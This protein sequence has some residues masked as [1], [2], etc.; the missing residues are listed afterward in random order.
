[1][2]GD[3]SGSR[4]KIGMTAS[5]IEQLAERVAGAMP[6]LNP[7]ERRVA[8]ALYRLLAGGSPVPL[9]TVAHTLGLSVDVVSDAVRRWPGVFYDDAQRVIGFW[10]LAQPE[11]SHRVIVNGTPL[12]AWCA[13]D[14]L[15]IP[16][17]L[18]KTASVESTCATT[19]AKI[20]LTVGPQGVE[21]VSPAS[22][23]VSFLTPETPFDANMILSFWHFVLFFASEE[24][25]AEWTANHPNTFLLSLR[26]AFEVGRLA[27]CA[28]FGDMLISGSSA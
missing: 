21:E 19:G 9:D 5:T 7:T 28:K 25:G 24:A 12:F 23:V 2:I 20:S 11:M 1:M 17:I 14:T 16:A 15:F 18:G 6:R 27:N 10:G 22:T 13:W 4:R 8:V 26:D 3:A